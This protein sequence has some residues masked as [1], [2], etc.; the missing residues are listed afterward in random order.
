ML[1]ALFGAQQFF[2]IISALVVVDPRR[3][4]A[5]S[6]MSFFFTIVVII[7]LLWVCFSLPFD[8][9]VDTDFECIVH[10]LLDQ[11]LRD[12]N[13]MVAPVVKL[14]VLVLFDYFRFIYFLLIVEPFVLGHGLVCILILNLCRSIDAK[15]HLQILANQLGKRLVFENIQLPGFV[16]VEQIQSESVLHGAFLDAL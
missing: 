12:G 2:F 8:H 1:D 14:W 7:V 4:V 15:V 16:R 10:H 5:G 13:L 3:S 9:A 6:S 11:F